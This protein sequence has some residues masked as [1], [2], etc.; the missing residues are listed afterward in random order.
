MH[1]LT[2]TQLALAA[3]LAVVVVALIFTSRSKHSRSGGPE[4]STSRGP[5]SLNFSCARCSTQT[6]H[7]RRTVNAWEKGSRQF[8]CNNCHKKWREAQPP[9]NARE[10]FASRPGSA[11]MERQTPASTSRPSS[12]QQSHSPAK[13]GC[14]GVLILMVAVP[15]VAAVER[16][17]PVTPNV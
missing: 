12:R 1:S 17:L 2:S 10:S 4:R 13:S 6:A 11:R 3:A 15:A 8:F 7:T 14:L 5:A 16:G 9:S